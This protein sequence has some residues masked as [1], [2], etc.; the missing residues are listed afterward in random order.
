M[1][2]GETFDESSEDDLPN[3][4]DMTEDSSVEHE[5][6]VDLEEVPN[7]TI[8]ELKLMEE[9]VELEGEVTD[10]YHKQPAGAKN[11]KKS[12][13]SNVAADHGETTPTKTNRIEPSPFLRRSPRSHE[14]HGSVFIILKLVITD[15]RGV[16]TRLDIPKVIIL[17]HGQTE[18]G[19]TVAELQQCLEDTSDNRLAVQFDLCRL[20]LLCANLAHVS[21]SFSLS[22]STDTCSPTGAQLIGMLHDFAN[23]E[24]LVKVAN[25]SMERLSLLESSNTSF[26]NNC[27]TLVGAHPKSCD[28]AEGLMKKIINDN[29]VTV[30]FVH[31]S[32]GT[33]LH[34]STKVT[35]LN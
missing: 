10:E 7:L 3:E 11:K 31:R 18:K 15:L 5:E 34:C 9:N 6:P 28:S 13:L 24:D 33:H 17:A 14:E 29:M 8:E 32:E 1:L 16:D 21:M 19:Q 26:E 12:D 27:A 30:K 23:C 20:F 4:C 25:V 22:L 2:T 35:C